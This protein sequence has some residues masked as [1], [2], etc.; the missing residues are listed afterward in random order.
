MGIIKPSTPFSFQLLAGQMMLPGQNGIFSAEATCSSPSALSSEQSSFTLAAHTPS[1]L[2][3]AFKGEASMAQ[4]YRRR[5]GA[6]E[7][8]AFAMLA[9]NAANRE[10]GP[11]SLYAQL[12][13]GDTD[14]AWI[15]AEPEGTVLRCASEDQLMGDMTAVESDNR[16]TRLW[17]VK[18]LATTDDAR[19]VLPLLKAMGDEDDEIRAIAANG[20]RGFRPARV[21]G[22]LI[23]AFGDKNPD[24]REHAL[25]IIVEFKDKTIPLLIQ[26]FRNPNKLVRAGTAL[27]LGNLGD[28]RAISPLI[29]ALQ[30]DKSPTVRGNAAEALGRLG[31]ASA[32]SPLVRAYENNKSPAVRGQVIDALGRLRNARAL[33][34]L[35]MALEDPNAAV[36]AK[37]VDALATLGDRLATGPH[38][39]KALKDKSAQVRENAAW[40]LG[41]LG[42]QRAVDALIQALGKD[43]SPNVRVGA[44]KAL[45]ELGNIRAA[46]ALMQALGNKNDTV[47][48]FAAEALEE[49]AGKVVE[50]PPI[51]TWQDGDEH[52]RLAARAFLSGMNRSILDELATR[53]DPKDIEPLIQLLGR[54]REPKALCEAL[55][56]LHTHDHGTVIPAMQKRLAQLSWQE[57]RALRRHVGLDFEVR[58]EGEEPEGDDGLLI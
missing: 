39:N 32:I 26:A 14:G 40:T 24:V 31:D 15:H 38:I 55:E 11:A 33:A 58:L 41:P 9:N 49:I 17:A 47:R 5:E 6:I 54:L 18:R 53:N 22:P 56:Y 7:G 43:R 13:V 28:A 35:T 30:D 52:A 3:G 12:S 50:I 48:Y 45:G 42:D 19:A 8:E 1:P 16:G 29:T 10:G 4:L 23:K 51:E 46:A 37:A 27:T 57:Q 36:R 2:K 34:Y 25:Q 20:L 44:A 21:M